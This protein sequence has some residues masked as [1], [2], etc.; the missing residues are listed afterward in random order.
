[1]SQASDNAVFFKRDVLSAVFFVAACDAMLWLGG[2]IARNQ[3]QAATMWIGVI[4][5]AGYF[6]Y[7]WNLFF[8]RFTAKLSLR[9]G[10][11]LIMALGGGF[12]LAAATTKNADIYCTLL[13][14]ILLMYGLFEVQYNTTVRH[15]YS[16]AER[17]RRLSRR[18]LA[19]SITATVL[20]LV[21]GFICEGPAGHTPALLIAGVMMLLG[22]MVF[23]TIRLPNEPR[24]E[25]F[26]ALHVAAAALR[27]KPLRRVAGMLMLYG[28]VGAGSHT[29]LVLLYDD[30]GMSVSQVGQLEA[31]RVVGLLLGYWLITPRLKFVGG[32]SNYR[33]CYVGAG[34]ATVIYFVVGTSATAWWTFW[35]LVA[36]Q[37]S[38]GAGVAVFDLAMQTTGINL[39]PPGKTT[40]YVNTLLIVQGTRGVVMPILVA[41]VISTWGMAPALTATVAL[42]VLCAGIVLLPNIDALAKPAV[43]E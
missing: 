17:P 31:A 25:Q 20:L 26:N 43:T 40:L 29:L 22:S 21:F 41:A 5:S 16:E 32:L 15:L 24:M 28:W 11:Y 3:L 36:A 12:T 7:L 23:R 6:G 42:G 35:A 4:G 14:F 39:A 8:G 30:R 34:I 33:W 2:F 13:I 19:A 18:R 37:L 27:D 9:R 10:M 38:F 1:M